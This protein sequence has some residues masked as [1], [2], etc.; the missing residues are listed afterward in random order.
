VPTSGVVQARD[1]PASMSYSA[2]ALGSASGMA[3]ACDEPAMLP[4]IRA[5]ASGSVGGKTPVRDEP[6]MLPSDGA[7][8]CDSPGSETPTC[9]ISATLSAV[10]VRC[11]A[12]RSSTK[13]AALSAASGRCRGSN[14]IS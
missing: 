2:S 10:S 6:L 11:E 3:P 7:D 14:T 13:A 8:A 5:D 12:A 1:E 9:D 4:S